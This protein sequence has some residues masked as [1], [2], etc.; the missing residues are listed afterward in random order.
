MVKVKDV[1]TAQPV[2]LNEGD[3]MEKAAE[4]FKNNN[5]HHIPVLNDDDD[6]VGILSSTDLE[7]S[8]HGDTL[9][10]VEDKAS[11]NDTLLKTNLVYK[12]MKTH[13]VTINQEAPIKDA[14]TMLKE[15]NFRCLPVMHEDKLTGIITNQD[16]L[17]YFMNKLD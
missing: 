3:T 5:F 7:R 1:M 2:T 8:L 10:K 14:Y 15:N 4:L 17:D 13:I 6:L 12:S 11:Y 16:L 9:F